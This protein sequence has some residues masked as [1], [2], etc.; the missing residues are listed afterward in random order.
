MAGGKAKDVVDG[1]VRVGAQVDWSAYERIF[2]ADNGW[3]FAVRADGSMV[4]YQHRNFKDGGTDVRGPIRLAGNW[5]NLR[6][7]FA[8]LPSPPVIG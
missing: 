3:I 7:V 6:G 4:C 2:G 5:S 1:P 8:S